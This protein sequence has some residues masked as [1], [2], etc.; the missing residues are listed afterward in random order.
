MQESEIDA[1]DKRDDLDWQQT[2]VG[3][4]LASVD[5]KARCLTSDSLTGRDLEHSAHNQRCKCSCVNSFLTKNKCNTLSLDRLP[6]K[7]LMFAAQLV[8][9]VVIG[10]C[11]E[12]RPSPFD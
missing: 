3:L 8:N 11:A 4:H 7:V 12:R 9:A 6:G 2:V 5:V 10:A 1:G